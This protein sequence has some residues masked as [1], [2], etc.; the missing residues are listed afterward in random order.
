LTL[1]FAKIR[2]KHQTA[3]ASQPYRKKIPKKDELQ[4]RQSSQTGG[5]CENESEECFASEERRVKNEE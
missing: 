4:S 5:F 3:N 2:K 1:C